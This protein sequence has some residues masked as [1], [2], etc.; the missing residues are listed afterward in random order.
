MLSGRSKDSPCSPLTVPVR[1]V[2]CKGKLDAENVEFYLM[3]DFNCNL[4][5]PQLDTYINL[6]E[7]QQFRLRQVSLWYFNTRLGQGKQLCSLGTQTY[8]R[9][10]LAS[11][12]NNVCEP[13]P[14]IDF[15]DVGILNQL[16][17]SSSSPRT[18]ARGI[19][20]EHSSFILS[21]NLIGQ[22]ETK[23][24][25]S[26][27]S[28]PGSGSQTLFFG[29]TKWQPEIRL[30]SQARHNAEFNIPEFEFAESNCTYFFHFSQVEYIWNYLK[31]K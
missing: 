31:I 2:A 16:Q 20:C 8:L 26:Q 25:T 5:S 10:S 23:V 28:F 7:I 17:F 1:W 3:G 18:T 21:W 19:R 12:E 13:E 22:G 6:L 11:A 24:I 30:R 15:C 27:K 4:A 14:G 29:G 9:L